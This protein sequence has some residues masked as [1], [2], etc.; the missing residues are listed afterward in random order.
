[1]NKSITFIV[2]LVFA[3]AMTLSQSAYVAPSA[4]A[5]DNNTSTNTNNNQKEES[6]QGEQIH[7]LRVSQQ[8]RQPDQKLQLIIQLH[9]ILIHLLPLQQLHLNHQQQQA[10]LLLHPHQ[11]PQQRQQ[12]GTAGQSGLSLK[13]RISKV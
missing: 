3:L 10:L 2:T 9:Q 7:L 12:Q 11:H 13:S 8:K 1:M 4:Q 5:K 6:L